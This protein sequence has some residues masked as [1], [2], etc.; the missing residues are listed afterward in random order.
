VFKSDGIVGAK[1]GIETPY[2]RVEISADTIHGHPIT[3]T[4]YTQLT[5]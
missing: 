5:K 3:S 4:E 2:V 1:N